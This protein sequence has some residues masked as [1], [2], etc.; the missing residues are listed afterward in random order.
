VGPPGAKKL[1]GKDHVPRADHQRDQVIAEAAEEERRQHV[2]HHH[3]AVHRHELV[4]GIGVDE[5]E[6]ARKA[7]LQAHQP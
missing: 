1:V 3:H 7:E 6:D 4:I 5:R 2:D